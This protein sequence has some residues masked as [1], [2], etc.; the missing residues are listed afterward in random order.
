MNIYL[1]E[2]DILFT[3]DSVPWR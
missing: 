2:L 1:I 3:E